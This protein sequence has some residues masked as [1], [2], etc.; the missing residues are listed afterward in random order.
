MND[1]LMIAQQ[2]INQHV[3]IFKTIQYHKE[4]EKKVLTEQQKKL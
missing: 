4:K 2:K 3:F 1:G